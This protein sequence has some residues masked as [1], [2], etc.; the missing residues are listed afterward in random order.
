MSLVTNDFYCAAGAGS[1][2]GRDSNAETFRVKTVRRHREG[3]DVIGE[4]KF[5]LP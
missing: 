3:I 4:Y 2:H 5:I 1:L